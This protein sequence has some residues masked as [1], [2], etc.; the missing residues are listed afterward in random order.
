LSCN[1]LHG[2]EI[3]AVLA[4]ALTGQQVPKSNAAAWD[5]PARLDPHLALPTSVKTLGLKSGAQPT[6]GMADARRIFS[7]AHPFRLL[8]APYT[9]WGPTKTVTEVFEFIVMPDEM[10]ALQGSLAYE[11]VE[12]FHLGL[13]EFPPG[14]HH[15]GRRWAQEQKK[16]LLGDVETAFILNPKVGNRDNARRLQC[17]IRLQALMTHVKQWRVHR[18][19][20]YGLSLPL[21]VTSSRREFTS[22]L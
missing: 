16:Q 19:D 11:A 22:G 12:E 21:T 9:Q 15:A 6:V 8:V 10:E 4:Q 18:G 13:K 14:T 3:E 17:S 7:I 1:Q 2:V 20:F 5:I